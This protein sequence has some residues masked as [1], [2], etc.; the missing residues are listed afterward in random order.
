MSLKPP[1]LC[2][3]LLA[4]VGYGQQQATKPTYEQLAAY[5]DVVQGQ[6]QTLKGQNRLLEL[7]NAD[8]RKQ[9]ESLK[10]KEESK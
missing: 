3:F 10:A 8:L 5:L 2:L 1:L 4:A 9:I 7:E 6:A